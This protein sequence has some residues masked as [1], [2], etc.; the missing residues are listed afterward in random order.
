M[1]TKRA[2]LLHYKALKEYADL[3][4]CVDEEDPNCLF[5]PLSQTEADYIWH[6][7]RPYV[8]VI[9]EPTSR[10]YYL[11]RN[12]Q[13]IISVK[14]IPVPIGKE[15]GIPAELQRVITHET[16]RNHQASSFSTPNWAS[17]LPTSEFT[18]YWLY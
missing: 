5:W 16:E 15:A 2:F 12:Y 1:L 14:D 6:F 10:G 4:S 13:H 17:K 9:H 18:T 8:C 3:R 11:D 7:L